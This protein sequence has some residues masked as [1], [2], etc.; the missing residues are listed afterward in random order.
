VNGRAPAPVTFSATASGSSGPVT[1]ASFTY[2]PARS[3]LRYDVRVSGVAAPRI[4]SVTLRRRDARGA[5]RVVHV[6]SG[7]NVAA[8]SGSVVLGMTNREALANGQ[9]VLTA[10][11]DGTPPAD[12]RLALPTAPGVT[13]ET[14][15]AR[16]P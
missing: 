3:T 12:A 15:R 9:L 5:M 4:V 6:L 13:R 2:E 7:P 1:R 11:M 10:M 8:A 16:G 14:R